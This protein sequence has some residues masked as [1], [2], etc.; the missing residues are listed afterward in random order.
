M[1]NG[2]SV[3]AIVPAR[4]GSKGI[5]DKNM[6]SIRGRSLISIA[7]D[8]LNQPALSWIDYKVL[9]TDSDR[10][11]AHGREHGL[12]VPFLRDPRLAS[13]HTSAADTA[14]NVLQTSEEHFSTKFGYIFFIEPTCP[15]RRVSDLQACADLLTSGNTESTLTV[16]QVDSKFNP[17]K[18]LV[19]KG[20]NV[21][22]FTERGI[23][24]THRQVLEDFFIRNGACYALTRSF[25]LKHRSFVTKNTAAVLIERPLVNIDTAFELDL[26]NAMADYFFVTESF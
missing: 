5:P 26:C 15:F 3:L 10:Y 18:L 9:S 6:K 14:I 22:F 20:D 17:D 19:L 4:S 16:S 8:L 23:S 12:L 24:I 2:K 11:A 7:A 25:L 21:D 1:L 13:D